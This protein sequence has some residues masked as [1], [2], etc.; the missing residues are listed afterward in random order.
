[1]TLTKWLQFVG[2]V[3]GLII[4]ADACRSDA[5]DTQ[6]AFSFED[7]TPFFGWSPGTITASPLG[8]KALGTFANQTVTLYLLDVLPTGSDP[9]FWYAPRTVVLSFDLLLTG[10]WLGDYPEYESF[11]QISAQ[12]SALFR[13][14]FSTI[15]PAD[16]PTT[17]SYPYAYGSGSVAPGTG[18]FVFIDQGLSAY[19]VQTTFPLYA[20]QPI[21][22][23]STDL[24]ID[25]SASDLLPS[26]GWMLDNVV[27]DWSQP[28]PEP[29]GITL[30]AGGLAM[31]LV[32]QL[33]RLA[34][35]PKKCQ[36]S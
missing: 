16:D 14:T 26:A 32:L 22:T 9:A 1:M 23:S 25:F 4:V 29:A 24:Q 8:G 5:S 12:R 36:W 35:S 3:A 31:V 21:F 18:S 7:N 33:A 6:D 13:T 34:R 10:T 30:I 28:V 17:Q 20:T 19:H 15:D 27:V 11:F 2:V